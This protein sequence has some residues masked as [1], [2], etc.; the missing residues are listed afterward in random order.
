[1]ARRK[2]TSHPSTDSSVSVRN[3]PRSTP[4]SAI[5]AIHRVPAHLARRFHQ[6]CL[7]VLA[8]VTDPEGIIPLQFAVL[9][10]L[11]DVPGIDQRRLAQRLG[12][13]P[14]TT[15]HLIDELEELGFV[16]RR[17]DP[18]DRRARILRLTPSGLK[19][20]RRLRPAMIAAHARIMV[21][22]SSAEQTKLIELL[23][24]VVE[25]NEAYARPGNGRRRLRRDQS[26][27]STKRGDRHAMDRKA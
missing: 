25:A 19:L 16:D 11:D 15:G 22:L 12:I 8:E 18:V 14:A 5:P 6:L 9:A 13:D 21:P 2:Q 26:L 7:G 3:E 4:S 17:I 23:T 27:P 1:M 20:R 10:S 24:R